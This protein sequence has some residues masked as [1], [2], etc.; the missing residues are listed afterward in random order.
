[1]S[2][3]HQQNQNGS[4]A[5]GSA[6]GQKRRPHPHHR[7]RKPKGPN[8]QQQQ[9][10]NGGAPAAPARVAA[11]M[12]MDLDL[13]D[14]STV[15]TPSMTPRAATPT[16]TSSTFSDVKFTD[17]L[18][19]GLISQQ[20]AKGIA[21]GGYE[22]CTQVQAMTLPTCLTGE[23]V[24]AQARTGTGKTLAFL[25]PSI[26]NLLRAP[27][28]PPKGQISVL[29]LSPTRELAIQ[30]EESAKTLLSG[31]PF[32]AQHVVGG[33]N[34]NSEVKRLQTERCDFLI[35]TPGRLLDHLQNSG[36]KQKMSGLRTF[37]F[38]EA[39]RLLEQGFRQDCERIISHLPPRHSTP[40]QTLMFSATI[41]QQVHQLSSLAL[42]PSHKFI[43]TIPPDEQNT[44][45]SV[46][47][48]TVLPDSLYDLF[49]ASL[50]VLKEEIAKHGDAT[51]VMFFLPTA[52]A[53]GLV[54]SLF[55]RIGLQQMVNG[56]EVYEIHSRKSQ[57]A[58]NSAAEAFKS[59]KG[60][61]LFSS[62]VTARG[63]DFP[64]VTTVIQVGLPA[65]GE[66]YIH[67]LGRTA[68]AGGTAK[69]VGILILAPFETFFLRK[70]IV[71]TL[72]LTPHPPIAPSELEVCRATLAKAMPLVG[73]DEK[74]QFYAASLGFYKASMRD[75][76][77][78]DAG[79]MVRVWNEFATAP[80]QAGGLGCDQ[81]PGILA[82]TVGKMGLKGT[83]GL[84]IVRELP[85]KEGGGGGGRG[86]NGGGGGGGRGGG[87]GGRGGG[88]GGGR[89]GGRGGRGRGQ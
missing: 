69:G 82:Q 36:L 81:V 54:A 66:Q 3:P 58:R 20:T 16:T 2:A 83:P 67:R 79:A 46:P 38:D 21:S 32:K 56:F 85:G 72:P 50:A 6:G 63:M 24:L 64:N 43:S 30:I 61:V 73:T 14:A 10:S 65:S 12:A 44:H 19:Q 42:L 35:A 31:T 34:M 13:S 48:T 84:N 41:P 45:Q 55:K 1:M 47:Q 11:T 75:A 68:R 59:A 17:F 89:G 9:Q 71:N 74:A 51:K 4:A 57:S 53:T 22:Y 52:R 70:P 40:R 25:I 80:V 15:T 8:Q 7:Q 62:D 18:A 28:Q 33:T 27:T 23:D 77:R 49:P 26:E 87:R 37:I 39:D 78:G 5:N 60:G 86:G 76:F 29:V 88:G